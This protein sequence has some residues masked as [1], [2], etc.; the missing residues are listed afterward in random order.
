MRRDGKQ[1]TRKM[2]WPV[3]AALHKAL[4]VHVD[5][6]QLPKLPQW[7]MHQKRTPR[8]LLQRL[9]VFLR[10]VMVTHGSERIPS[11]NV[12]HWCTDTPF[13]GSAG[14]EE[15]AYR[16]GHRLN[17]HW[18]C[19]VGSTVTWPRPWSKTS[20]PHATITQRGYWYNGLMTA[21]CEA[22]LATYS[23]PAFMV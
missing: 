17:R 3:P 13:H 8:A 22:P 2:T 11:H 21:L 20:A 7:P 9:Q 15:D 16:M 6:Q 14:P 1:Q 5:R 19:N 18:T 23:P 10:N 12:L 4:S